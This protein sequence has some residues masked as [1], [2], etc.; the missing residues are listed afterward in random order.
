MEQLIFSL[1]EFINGDTFPFDH[2][3]RGKDLS[4]EI[5]IKNLS[6]KAKTLAVTLEDISHPIKDFTHWLIW[7]IPAAS[8][9][10]KAIPKGKYVS[11]IGA[12]QGV[13]YGM[14]RYAGPKPPHGKTHTYRITVYSL[15]CLIDLSANKRKKHFLKKAESHILQKGCLEYSFE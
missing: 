15:D 1:P 6:E 8:K 10:I 4:P 12:T 3:G 7:N 13:A 11:D 9:I 14:H 2:T 5:V